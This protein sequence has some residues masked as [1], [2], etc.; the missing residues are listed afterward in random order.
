MQKEIKWISIN[1]YRYP[2]VKPKV[3]SKVNPKVNPKVQSKVNPKVQSKVNPQVQ[4]KVN[5]I[6]N[7]GN[8]D[9]INL[10]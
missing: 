2:K 10:I 9:T 4:S 5:K 3:Q 7:K 1:S 8:K 6:S